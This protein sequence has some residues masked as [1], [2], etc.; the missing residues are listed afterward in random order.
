MGLLDALH[1]AGQ[2]GLGLNH[3]DVTRSPL[4]GEGFGVEGAA[5]ELLEVAHDVK[6]LATP[7]IQ[8]PPVKA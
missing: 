5:H 3:L 2:Y 6:A 8:G 4:S 1:D 7:H